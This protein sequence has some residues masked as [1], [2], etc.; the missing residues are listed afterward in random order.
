MDAATYLKQCGLLEASLPPDPKTCQLRIEL[1]LP[2]IDEETEEEYAL[3]ISFVEGNV[4][5]FNRE[6]AEKHDWCV[7]ISSYESALLAFL[8]RRAAFDA[9]L[10]HTY[11]LRDTKTNDVDQHAY[12]QQAS[13]AIA[14][15]VRASDNLRKDI[16]VEDSEEE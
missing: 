13:A 5:V 11:S 9:V 1:L 7:R 15:A 16:I 8:A 4:S 2:K 12:L 10:Y 3:L 14:M 6:L